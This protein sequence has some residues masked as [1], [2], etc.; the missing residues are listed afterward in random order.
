MQEDFEQELDGSEEV[1]AL[2]LS[3]VPTGVEIKVW[4]LTDAAPPPQIPEE[5]Q[6]FAEVFSNEG[7]GAFPVLEDAVHAIETTGGDPPFGPIYNLSEVQLRA[8]REYLN[9]NLALG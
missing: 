8:L 5:Y 2:Y 7:A 1:F 9:E 3:Q 4:A 6:D